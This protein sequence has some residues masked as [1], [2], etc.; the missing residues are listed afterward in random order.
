MRGQAEEVHEL[1]H[2]RHGGAE[3]HRGQGRTQGEVQAWPFQI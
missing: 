2:G 3:G 1:P